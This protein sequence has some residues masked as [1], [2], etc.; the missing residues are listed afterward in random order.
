MENKKRKVKTYGLDDNGL[1]GVYAVSVVEFPAIEED[2][3]ALSKAKGFKLAAVNEEKRMLYGPALIPDKEIMRLD[4]N[5]EEYFVTF[6]RAVVEQLAQLFFKKNQH[7]NATFEH[8]FSVSGMTVVETWIKRGEQDTSLALGLSSALPEGTWFIGMKV[9]NDDV[10][11]E[12]KAG[13]VKGFS[14]EG[15]FMD[16]GE[17]LSRACDEDRI[18]AELETLLKDEVQH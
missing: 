5:G 1:L 4:D 11:G 3:V 14:I 7:H 17:K 16:I 18:F 13:K 10:W 2:F 9:D 6:P 15:M 8:A 12:V